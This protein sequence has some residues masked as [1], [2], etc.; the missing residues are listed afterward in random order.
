MVTIAR[1]ILT[2]SNWIS[3]NTMTKSRY[4]DVSTN[5]TC[6]LYIPHLRLVLRTRYVTVPSKRATSLRKKKSHNDNKYWRTTKQSVIVK[7]ALFNCTTIDSRKRDK[8]DVSKFFTHLR[9]SG[10]DWREIF[11]SSW[12]DNFRTAD[13]CSQKRFIPRDIRGVISNA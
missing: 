9:H 8:L 12:E 11:V 10:S 4:I 5:S 7:F 2:W 6:A 13:F 1:R 3:H